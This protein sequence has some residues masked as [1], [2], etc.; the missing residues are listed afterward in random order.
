MLAPPLPRRINFGERNVMRSSGKFC[1]Q[2]DQLL[3]GE[4]LH[5]GSA[6]H[7][8]LH[9]CGGQ[10]GSIGRVDPRRT[11]VQALLLSSG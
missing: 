7:H 11:H 2:C 4:S 6:G 9:A 5:R 3:C 8:N 10:P 1:L